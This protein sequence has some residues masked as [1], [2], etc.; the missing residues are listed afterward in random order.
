[1][2]ISKLFLFDNLKYNSNF[3]VMSNASRI[4]DLLRLFIVLSS[5]KK[6][7]QELSLPQLIKIPPYSILF[8]IINPALLVPT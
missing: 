1:M 7:N 6:N 2:K 3:I 4:I 8:D 5:T